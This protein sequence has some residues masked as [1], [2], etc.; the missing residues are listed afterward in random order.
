MH[1][2]T[3]LWAFSLGKVRQGSFRPDYSADKEPRGLCVIGRDI[4]F[5]GMVMSSRLTPG[6]SGDSCVGVA[7][8]PGSLGEI[9]DAAC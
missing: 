2:L 7:V 9:W 5:L 1:K 3:K 8:K 4:T 6:G